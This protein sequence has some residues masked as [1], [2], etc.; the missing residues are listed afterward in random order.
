MK[1]LGYDIA[2][3]LNTKKYDVMPGNMTDADH[4]LFAKNI[5][6]LNDL[7]V[8]S[9]MVTA[10]K[11]IILAEICTFCRDNDMELM[12]IAT[13]HRSDYYNRFASFRQENKEL[14][15]FL[16]DF[17]LMR[18]CNYYDSEEDVDVHN[19]LPD[20]YYYDWE[21]VSEEYTDQSTDYLTDVIEQMSTENIPY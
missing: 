1:P 6:A 15:S 19:I 20:S 21:H 4:L 18:G 17:L 5:E 11:L 2:F 7:S 10:D 14:S 8:P 13:P 16:N 12:V 9:D 3:D